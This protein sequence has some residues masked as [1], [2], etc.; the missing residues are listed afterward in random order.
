M[1]QER[2]GPLNGVIHS[3]GVIDYAGVIQRRTR[4]MTEPILAAKVKGTV[5]LDRLLKEKE[6]DFLVLCSSR[7]H[8][9]LKGFVMAQ[10]WGDE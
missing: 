8:Y 2:F 7:A 5:I 1:S 9:D 10:R 4:E 3:A 6:L